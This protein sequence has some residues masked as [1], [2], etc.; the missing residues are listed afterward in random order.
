MSAVRVVLRLLGLS[1]ALAAYHPERHYMR[2][3]GPACLR[4]MQGDGTRLGA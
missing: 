3:P 1:N 4:R 2:G